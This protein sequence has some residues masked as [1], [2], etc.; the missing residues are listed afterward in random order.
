MIPVRMEQLD[1]PHAAFDQASRQDAV[2]GVAAGTAGVGPVEFEDFVGLA[3]KV[4]QFG[5]AGLHAEGHLIL[6]DA[7]RHLGVAAAF[8]GAAVEFGEPVEHVAPQ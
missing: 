3:G 1:E 6:A 7:G 5:H 4:G 8:Q 2:G